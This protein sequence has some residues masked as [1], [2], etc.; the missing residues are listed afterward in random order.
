MNYTVQMAT[1]RGQ[2]IV[3]THEVHKPMEVVKS[4]ASDEDREIDRILQIAEFLPDNAVAVD[5]G[6]NVGLVSVP[7]ARAMAKRGGTVIAYEA[8]RLVY[9]MLAGNTALSGLENLI[10]T[11]AR[12]FEDTIEAADKVV[13]PIF[14]SRRP[15]RP[16]KNADLVRTTKLDQEALERLDFLKI[17]GDEAEVAILEGAAETIERCQP[18][19]W[20]TMWPDQYAAVHAWLKRRGYCMKIADSRGFCA[21]PESVIDEFPLRDLPPFDGKLNPLAVRAGFMRA[22]ELK[23]VG[24]G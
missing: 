22:P 24:N 12:V 14:R 2:F 17:Q 6:A 23:G 13:T 19:I 5:V 21:I 9:Y 20:I 18:I 1:P 16:R 11:Q 4:D 10:C 8:E 15:A 3:K 7:L